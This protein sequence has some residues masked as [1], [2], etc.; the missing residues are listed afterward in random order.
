[1]QEQEDFLLPNNHDI[2]ECWHPKYHAPLKEESRKFLE[3]WYIKKYGNKENFETGFSRIVPLCIFGG[4]RFTPYTR[5]R[6][7]ITYAVC[8]QCRNVVMC[9][10]FDDTGLEPKSCPKCKHCFEPGDYFM[11]CTLDHSYLSPHDKLIDPKKDPVITVLEACS[12]SQAGI[13][14]RDIIAIIL[15]LLSENLLHTGYFIDDFAIYGNR[16]SSNTI[17]KNLSS[18]FGYRLDWCFGMIK[19]KELGR[20]LLAAKQIT[21]K[22]GAIERLQ[23]LL[24]LERNKLKAEAW[25]ILAERI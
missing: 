16:I 15:I 23:E 2:S 9:G 1:M 24:A 20:I 10:Y 12:L 8:A 17:S 22:A 14:T 18:E 3:D 6:G 4:T 21:P 11:P 7:L 5:Y 19:I 25:K 13:P